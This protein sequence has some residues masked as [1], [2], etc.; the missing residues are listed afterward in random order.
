MTWRES[1]IPPRG[2]L[3]AGVVG[4]VGERDDC[5][6]QGAE[7]SERRRQLGHHRVRVPS[8]PAVALC[9]VRQQQHLPVPR[10]MMA[11]RVMREGKRDVWLYK[12][13]KHFFLEEFL[14]FWEE[15]NGL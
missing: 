14:N 9:R 15:K 10:L 3:R 13:K 5:A 7:V 1:N 12:N 8:H 6:G 2:A 4:H 11:T